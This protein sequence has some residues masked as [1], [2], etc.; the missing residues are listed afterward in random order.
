M[1][2]IYVQCTMRIGIL[3]S[4]GFRYF[5]NFMKTTV[6]LG[7]RERSQSDESRGSQIELTCQTISFHLFPRLPLDITFSREMFTRCWVGRVWD[8]YPHHNFSLWEYDLTRTT[9]ERTEDMERENYCVEN[10]ILPV[11]IGVS[12]WTLPRVYE[13]YYPTGI[14]RLSV[15]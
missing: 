5:P 1:T 6:Q 2:L 14:L 9:T 13:Q 7:D 11:L 4:V 8:I 10:C 12:P 3:Y 15:A